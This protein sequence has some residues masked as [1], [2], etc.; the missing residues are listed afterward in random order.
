[1][2]ALQQCTEVTPQCPVEATTYGYRPN[3]GVNTTLLVVFALCTIGQ[4]AI[5]VKDRIRAFATATAIGCLLE[6]LGYGGRLMMNDNPWT[7]SG[8]RLQ[9]V[10]IILAPTF[11]AAGI[12][13]TL[14]HLVQHL[15]SDKSRLPPRLY[16]WI[17]IICDAASILT[18]AAGGGLAASASGNLLD[19]G[20]DII[21]AGIAFQV[22][23]MSTCFLLAIDFGVRLQMAGRLGRNVG[24]GFL[25]YLSATSLAFLTILIRCVYRYVVDPWNRRMSLS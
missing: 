25:V 10:C 13:L 23:T 8:F 19:I 22:A 1:M 6:T 5:A 15:G 21:I 24:R 12:Y 7:T 2:S 16:P 17:F 4:V 3:L 11:L 20:N 18:Q 14:K 9:I